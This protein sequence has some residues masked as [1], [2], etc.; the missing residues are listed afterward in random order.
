MKQK[1]TKSE[2][3]DKR[4][5]LSLKGRES[6]TICKELEEKLIDLEKKIGKFDTAHGGS[7]GSAIQKSDSKDTE[8]GCR[9]STVA[10]RLRRKSLD[11]ATSSEPMKVLI[12]MTSLENRVADLQKAAADPMNIIVEDGGDDSGGNGIDGK[13]REIGRIECAWRAKMTEIAAK[14]RRLHD[15]GRLD[16]EAKTTLLTE[17][18]ATET[19]FLDK[20]KRLMSN[21][22]TAAAAAVVEITDRIRNELES[23]VGGDGCDLGLSAEH[24]TDVK[25]GTEKRVDRFL[26]DRMSV[27]KKFKWDADE[28]RDIAY[29]CLEDVVADAEMH[30]ALDYCFETSELVRADNSAGA[31]LIRCSL[32]RAKLEKWLDDVR[33]SVQT[34]VDRVVRVAAADGERA[35][36]ADDRNCLREYFEVSVLR[37]MLES[38][39]SL[40]VESK[41]TPGDGRTTEVDIAQTLSECLYLA[42]KM[43]QRLPVEEAAAAVDDDQRSLL[44]DSLGQVETEVMALQEMIVV[45]KQRLP[46]AA[47]E[48]PTGHE[49]SASTSWIEDVCD[50]CRDLRV[51]IASLHTYLGGQCREC[52]KCVYLQDKLDGYGR[53]RDALLE[54]AQAR[55]RAELAELK[56]RLEDEKRKLLAVGD[57]ERVALKDRVKKLEKRLS[58][59]DSEYSQQMDNLRLSYQIALASNASPSSSTGAALTTE[60]STKLRYQTEVEHLRVSPLSHFSQSVCIVRSFLYVK[61][62]QTLYIKI[63]ESMS[64]SISTSM[65]MQCSKF[66]S[67]PIFM[68]MTTP[69]PHQCPCHMSMSVSMS[70]TLSLA[71]SMSMSMLM[72]HAHFNVTCQYHISTSMSHV[73]V[74]V[75]VNVLI[76]AHVNVN[77]QVN[78]HIHVYVYLYLYIFIFCISIFLSLFLYLSIS[79]LND[80]YLYIVK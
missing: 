32:N 45:D 72:S 60:E 17:K 42:A 16:D 35:A 31:M 44:H 27:I 70:I 33:G 10:S 7:G 1:L 18:V 66:M 74:N 79:K 57:R 75:H 12:R 20:L 11:S 59:L 73:H 4:R 51:Q 67:T 43:C 2:G 34:M 47:A 5:S 55:H 37:D 23:T 15:E 63:E 8:T 14:R 40:A 68:S 29:A 38:G 21:D 54:T 78:V 48:P 46:V 19:V 3:R 52:Q 39:L 53:E 25:D 30:M 77:I 69:A 61:L 6:F 26:D 49:S 64:I 76:H 9:A 56:G 65:P 71:M 41:K 36:A 24:I 22:A 62:G 13:E 28:V 80:I 50:K 58:A